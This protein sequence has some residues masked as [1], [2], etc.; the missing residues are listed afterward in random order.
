MKEAA[1]GCGRRGK[2]YGFWIEAADVRVAEEAGS[3][4]SIESGDCGE[5]G[6]G[7]PVSASGRLMQPPPE[8]NIRF[9]AH[10]SFGRK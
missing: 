4:P 9:E 3:E 2:R 1:R 8:R 7:E 5:A 10:G 6:H